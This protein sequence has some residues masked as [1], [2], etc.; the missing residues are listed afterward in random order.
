MP[1]AAAWTLGAALVLFLVWLSALLWVVL[2]ALSQNR[3]TLQD[4]VE[5]LSR[6]ISSL[7]ESVDGLRVGQANANAQLVAALGRLERLERQTWPGA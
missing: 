4:T 2:A 3:K 5:P 6:A 7:S 1:A